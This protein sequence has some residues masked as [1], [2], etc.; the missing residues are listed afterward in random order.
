LRDQAPVTGRISDFLPFLPFSSGEQAVVAHKS[1]LE[2]TRRVRKPINLSPGASEQLL[3][4]VRIHIRKDGSVCR[5]IAE[6]EY[7]SELGA[8]SLITGAKVVEDKLVEAYLE[9]D[10]TIKESDRP[11]H[12]DVDVSGGEVNVT[13]KAYSPL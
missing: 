3:G 13:M 11:V 1:L 12:F 2:L 6:T 9:V 10:D 8:R 5:A 7:S 4:N